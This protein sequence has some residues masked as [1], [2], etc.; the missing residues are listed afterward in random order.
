MQATGVR[1]AKNRH[2]ADAGHTLASWVSP[3]SPSL[4]A[5]NVKGVPAGSSAF[6]ALTPCWARSMA[7]HGEV[8]GHAAARMPCQAE[9]RR[10]AA[11]TA[12]VFSHH[13]P[14]A[15]AVAV[16]RLAESGLRP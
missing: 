10:M 16:R 4:P 7:F 3:R 1:L 14:T 15:F 5:Q 6:P 11:H 12:P 2:P 8:M 9:C 13:D